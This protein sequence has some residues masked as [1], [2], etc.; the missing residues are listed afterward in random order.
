MVPLTLSFA[1]DH[2][3]DRAPSSPTPS[4]SRWLSRNPA[5]PRPKS[6]GM[7][8]LEEVEYEKRLKVNARR[9]AHSGNGSGDGSRP[10]PPPEYSV[11]EP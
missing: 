6:G 5:K 11:N 3:H 9:D 1:S 4:P 8:V 7:S 2:A 10:D